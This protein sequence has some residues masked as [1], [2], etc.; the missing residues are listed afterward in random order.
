MRR[1][2]IFWSIGVGYG[3][4]GHRRISPHKHGTEGGWQC[5]VSGLSSHGKCTVPHSPSDYSLLA[6]LT[7]KRKRSASHQNVRRWELSYDITNAMVDC[8]EENRGPHMFD[9]GDGRCCRL[10][11]L[12]RSDG[13]ARQKSIG[14]HMTLFLKPKNAEL[15][16]RRG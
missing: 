16:F 7:R 2:R 8:A 13:K 9:G 14:L 11:Y 10:G 5:P 4:T 1:S 6:M 12:T 3:R 15:V